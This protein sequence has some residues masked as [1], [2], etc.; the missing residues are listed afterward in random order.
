M[1]FSA[2]PQQERHPGR[3]VRNGTDTA[4][5][6]RCNLWRRREPVWI[7][8]GK[9]TLHP[10]VHRAAFQTVKSVQQCAVGDF[11]ADTRKFSSVLPWPL[12]EAWMGWRKGLPHLSLP[13]A[14][15]RSDIWHESRN[16]GVQ[17]LLPKRR[18]VS[19]EKE[20]K[21]I[22]RRLRFQSSHTAARPIPLI[23][24]MLLF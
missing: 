4:G 11:R 23:R 13:S 8:V 5:Q 21:T 20:R 1:F 9:N 14:R 19:V 17:D 10:D 15:H 18:Q 6:C 24:L 16:V 12:P 3:Y 22:H 7:E 2:F